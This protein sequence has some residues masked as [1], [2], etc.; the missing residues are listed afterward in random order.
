M[1]EEFE[2]ALAALHS[3]GR[4]RFPDDWMLRL[5]ARR[6]KLERAYATLYEQ[7]RDP[8]SYSSLS[9]QTAYVFAYAPTRAEYT[10]QYLVRHRR[11]FGR[12]LFGRP[13]VNIVSFG[14]GPASELVGLVRYL[15]SAQA[16]ELVEQID[17]T[18]YDKDGEWSGVATSVVEDLDTDIAI[19]VCYE[20]VDAISRKRMTQI[21][22]SA[23]DMV[24][25]SYIM[26]EL[27]KL[28][29]KDQIVE[30]F[31]TVLA[32][33]PV[34]SKILFLDNKHRIFID[35]FQSCKLVTGLKQKNDDGDQVVCDF[36]ALIGTFDIISRGLD[37][38]P[39]T[40]LNSVSKLIVRTNL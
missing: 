16:D 23:V 11:A 14:G 19:N 20:D 17:Y 21:D 35:F 36:P 12:A 13:K 1:M 33:L 32:G 26:S 22:L 40:D 29:R 25:F 10:R 8:I 39:R 3:A 24:I 30:N 5:E 28:G 9:A 31:R 34:G 7:D 2:A 4:R 37:W 6:I 27:A 18:V 38:L 15:E